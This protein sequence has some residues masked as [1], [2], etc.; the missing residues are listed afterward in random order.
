MIFPFLSRVEFSSIVDSVVSV[1]GNFRLIGSI[2]V[3][4]FYALS[5]FQSTD[6]KHGNCPTLMVTVNKKVNSRRLNSDFSN[7]DR[8]MSYKVFLLLFFDT[9]CVELY[10]FSSNTG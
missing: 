2:L 3:C 10:P 4:F 9:L 6:L 7:A 1:N 5:L 8:R